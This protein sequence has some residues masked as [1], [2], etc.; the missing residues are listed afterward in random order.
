PN[1]GAS[2]ARPTPNPAIIR[3]CR[4]SC[5]DRYAPDACGGGVSAA[6]VSDDLTR[7]ENHVASATARIA[8]GALWRILAAVCARQS[9]R[10]AL[11]GPTTQSLAAARWQ[12]NGMFSL[13]V[14][15]RNYLRLVHYRA[16]A[17]PQ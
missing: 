16:L 3:T 13:P 14:D 12:G 2:P 7:R 8:N 5:C 4:H 9:R 11:P 15:S 1:R 17:S 10:M 6:D